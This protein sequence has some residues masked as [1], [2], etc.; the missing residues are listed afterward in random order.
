M[1]LS[2]ASSIFSASSKNRKQIRNLFLGKMVAGQV[3]TDVA[4]YHTVFLMEKRFSHIFKIVENFD[5]NFLLL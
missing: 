2:I 4:F 3:Y 5:H 1:F